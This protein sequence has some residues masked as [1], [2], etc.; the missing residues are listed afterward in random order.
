MARKKEPER[1]GI[2]REKIA[3]AVQKQM[4]RGSI[5][6]LSADDIAK[7]VGMS[8]STMYVYFESKEQIYDYIACKSM[9]MFYKEIVQSL[10]AA[11]D[12]KH[13][14]FIRICQVMTQ[15]RENQPLCF[16]RMIQ[17][18]SVDEAKMAADETLRKT[19]E[20][21]EKINACIAAAMSGRKVD[22]VASPN[23][24]Q[25]VFTK[26]G[27]IYGLI[28]LAENKAEYI[29]KSMGISKEAFLEEGFEQLYR[30]DAQGE[31]IS[32]CRSVLSV[33][34]PM[35]AKGDHSA[36]RKSGGTVSV[37]KLC[38]LTAEAPTAARPLSQRT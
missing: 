29:E 21:G 37:C 24:I 32:V 31:N 30:L 16:E 36:G 7:A 11:R 26:W 9:E 13:E 19:Y 2:N 10:A 20:L 5:E 33:H 17:H 18:I 14:A 15:L 35:P 4:R 34:Q 3:D 38:G 28:T 6:Q 8:K 12:D 1:V 27:A 22:G 23:E 25:S